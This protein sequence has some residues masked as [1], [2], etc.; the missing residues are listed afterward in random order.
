MDIC[1][2]TDNTI[3]FTLKWTVSNNHVD[4]ITHCYV[5][6]TTLLGDSE[7]KEGTSWNGEPVYLGSAYASCYRVCSMHMLSNNLKEQPFGLELRVQPVTLSRRKPSV[8]DADSIT[9]W[10]SP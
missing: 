1:I 6:A 5:Y 7:A 8:D 3:S 4:P 9:V 2:S 10:F